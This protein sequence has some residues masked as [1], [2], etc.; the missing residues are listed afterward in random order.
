MKT[1]WIDAVTNIE[2]DDYDEAYDAVLE[3]MDTDDYRDALEEVISEYGVSELIKGL[4]DP[5]IGARL[6]EE[7]MN[8]AEQ[9]VLRNFLVEDEVEEDEEDEEDMTD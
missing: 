8:V 9:I 2:Y 3:H 4:T 5:D 7:I 6:Y 1:I